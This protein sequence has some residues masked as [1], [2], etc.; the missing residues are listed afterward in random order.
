MFQRPEDL[1]LNYHGHE[2]HATHIRYTIV[3]SLHKCMNV[4]LCC[5]ITSDLVD[6]S[7]WELSITYQEMSNKICCNKRCVI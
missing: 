6:N 2:N 5:L 1:I 3:V 7:V 4:L